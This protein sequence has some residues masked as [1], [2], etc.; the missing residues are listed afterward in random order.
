ML[1]FL[2][3]CLALSVSAGTCTGYNVSTCVNLDWT[4]SQCNNAYLFGVDPATSKITFDARQCIWLVGYCINPTT[5]NARCEPPCAPKVGGPSGLKCSNFGT[6][7]QCV[8]Y[9]ADNYGDRFCWWD[10]TTSS[11]KDSTYTCHD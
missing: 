6:Q 9:Y 4:Q 2:I 1:L 11:C 3:A 7:S 10:T 8:N 5:S